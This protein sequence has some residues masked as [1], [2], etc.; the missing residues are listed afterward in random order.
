MKKLESTFLNMFLVLTIISV[1]AGAGLAAV[2]NVTKEP[3]EKANLEKQQAAIK[4]VLPE[5]A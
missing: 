2:Y 3:I 5:G 4:A 1:V